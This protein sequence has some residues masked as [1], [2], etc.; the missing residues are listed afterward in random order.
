MLTS[1]SSL[2]LDDELD[3]CKRLHSQS[4]SRSLHHAVRVHFRCE[5]DADKG[6]RYEDV[7]VGWVWHKKSDSERDQSA[8]RVQ[9]GLHSAHTQSEAIG[10]ALLLK[11][12]HGNVKDPQADPTG[13]N[14]D[15]QDDERSSGRRTS[16][17]YGHVRHAQTGALVKDAPQASHAQTH[18]L[19]GDM[20]SART[21]KTNG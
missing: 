1:L 6:C 12:R 18:V 17:Q 19:D 9:G 4:P 14:A 21:Q 16:N 20:V 3:A 15:N 7:K 5:S 11:L 2:R 8:K 13:T 10:D